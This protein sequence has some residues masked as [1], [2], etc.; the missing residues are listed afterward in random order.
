MFIISMFLHSSTPLCDPIVIVPDILDDLLV[1]KFLC[2]QKDYGLC[3][4]VCFCYD[5]GE[6]DY[7]HCMP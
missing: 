5:P 7:K 1:I 6:Y 2:F 3:K 4:M